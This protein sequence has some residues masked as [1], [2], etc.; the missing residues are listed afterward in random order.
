[1]SQKA[2]AFWAMHT[3][4]TFLRIRTDQHADLL[5]LCHSTSLWYFLD[6]LYHPLL[7]RTSALLLY[8]LFRAV[9]KFLS[10]RLIMNSVRQWNSHQRHK[11]L[12]AHASR[13]ISRIHIS[14]RQVK[15]SSDGRPNSENFFSIIWHP[16]LR[17]SF[18][19]TTNAL[20]WKQTRLLCGF[21]KFYRWTPF[22]RYYELIHH[23]PTSNSMV[24]R[25]N[26]MRSSTAHCINLAQMWQMWE[27][28]V[29]FR[30]FFYV[31]E[32][33]QVIKCGAILTRCCNQWKKK[34]KGGLVDQSVL[35]KM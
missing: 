7:Y 12:T 13:D 5:N 8:L 1:M 31:G 28:G 10:I 20:T 25:L 34:E 17:F 18:L 3:L 15:M 33:L 11:F 32:F 24:C 2:I 4:S 9:K 26:F 22:T 6:V 19:P 21:I 35:I 29:L 30:R 27:T 14:G 23:I 16:R